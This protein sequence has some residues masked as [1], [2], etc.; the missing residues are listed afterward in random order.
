[1]LTRYGQKSATWIDLV[2]PTPM[3]VRGLMKEFG[4][5]PLIAEELLVPSFK[6]RVE[7]RGDIIYVILHFP[8]LRGLGNG[9]QE[10][11]I[12]FV[13]G[14]NF[15]ITT[16]YGNVDPLHAFAQAF[17]VNTVL[18]RPI[19]HQHGGHL[20]TAMARALYEA[21]IT[22]SHTLTQRLQDIEDRIFS[23]DERQMVIEISQTGRTLHDFRQALA[24]HKEMLTSLEPV[25]TRLFGAEFSYYL[26]DLIGAEE[27]VEHTIDNLYASLAELRETNNSLLSTKQNEIMKTLTVVAFIFLPLTFIGQLFGMSIPVPLQ[28]NPYAFFFILGGMVLVAMSIFMYFRHRGWI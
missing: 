14:K 15:L 21:L 2:A 18:G 17:E 10:Q 23:G 3:E 11:E 1:M 27:R 6:P 12:D 13:I 7:R 8:V 25:A 22:E 5:D 20:F 9:R 19:M 24:P 26:R 16:R 28:S 4:I